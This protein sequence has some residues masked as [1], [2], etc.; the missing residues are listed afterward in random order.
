MSKK[1][2]SN[3]GRLWLTKARAFNGALSSSSSSS[4]SRIWHHRSNRF[5]FDSRSMFCTSK[6]DPPDEFY[7]EKVEDEKEFL[8]LLSCAS[9]SGSIEN[10]TSLKEPQIKSLDEFMNQDGDGEAFSFSKIVADVHEMASNDR[11]DFEENSQY[12]SDEAYMKVIKDPIV[13]QM[14]DPD[15]GRHLSEFNETYIPEGLL[16]YNMPARKDSEFPHELLKDFVPNTA[17]E[18]FKFSEQGRRA[19]PGG[20][21]RQGKRGEMLCHKIDLDALNHL[22]VLTMRRFLSEDS[23]ILNRKS[24]GLCAKC[25]RKVAKN[26]KRGR[27]LGIIPHLSQYTLQDAR[28]LHRDENFH[29]VPKGHTHIRSRTVIGK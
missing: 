21:Q 10:L 3:V 20:R 13:Q 11:E 29:D 28:P 9:Q 27:Q 6:S 14:I 7:D 1:V 8:D 12:N 4:S 18:K 16:N 2:I 22:D 17:P 26:I 23:E 19:C 15:L 25:Q 5:L 24:T